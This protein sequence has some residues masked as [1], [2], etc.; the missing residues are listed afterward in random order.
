MASAALSYD[1][2][3]LEDNAEV[4]MQIELI[5]TKA[6]NVFQGSMQIPENAKITRIKDSSGNISEFSLEK[7][8]LT[9]K[10]NYSIAKEKEIV[11]I[12]MIWPNIIDKN[13]YGLNCSKLSFSGIKDIETT[14]NIEGNK[15]LSFE[16]SAGFNTYYSENKITVKGIGPV[17]IY[18]CYSDKGLYFK[19]YVLFGETI[20]LSE[21]E[22]YFDIIPLVL[23]IMPAFS[24]FPIVI[25]EDAHYNIE[26]NEY[27]QGTH[28]PGGVLIIKKSLFEDKQGKTNEGIITTIHETV[29][30]FNALALGWNNT[31]ASFF[32]EG[33]AKL[34][35]SIALERAEAYDAKLFYGEVKYAEGN[36]LFTLLPKGEVEDLLDYY[37]NN[38]TF[39]VE[40]NPS[41]VNN[42]AFGYAYGELYAKKY[43]MDYG[44]TK[45]QKAYREFV[46]INESITSEGKAY[47]KINVVLGATEQPCYTKSLQ[48]LKD[49]LNTVNAYHI[50]VPNQTQVLIVGQ[51]ELKGTKETSITEIK[52]MQKQKIIDIYYELKKR[53]NSLFEKIMLA[54]K[55]QIKNVA[56]G[57]V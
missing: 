48:E 37:L 3:L 23:G 24:R 56:E 11:D 35:E 14:V 2:N 26:I 36:K 8:D 16:A 40:W 50:M 47:D 32:D 42:R 44:I 52:D 17:N 33:I 15:I 13:Y 53:F 57:D 49:C 30:S 39:M 54:W 9:F 6:A 29:H 51:Q 27:S 18:L 38:R 20:N 46:E 55:S 34:I 19:H 10:T 25:M 1:L 45:L 22:D 41:N 31:Q 5:S 21:T 4:N 43:V 12:K 7:G 28:M